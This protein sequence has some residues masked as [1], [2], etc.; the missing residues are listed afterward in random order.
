MGS[1]PEFK[2]GRHNRERTVI[3][4]VFWRMFSET[5]SRPA[6]GRGC[7]PADLQTALWRQAIGPKLIESLSFSPSR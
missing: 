5:Q 3:P 1:A 6:A 4:V 7:Y 2:S